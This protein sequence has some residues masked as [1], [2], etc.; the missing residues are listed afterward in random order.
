MMFRQ[1]IYNMKMVVLNNP[2]LYNW[3]MSIK[4]E[5]GSRYQFTNCLNIQTLTNLV[6]TDNHSNDSFETCLQQTK[7]ELENERKVRDEYLRYFF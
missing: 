7:L 2:Q 3:I 4:I 1:K 5:K 6:K